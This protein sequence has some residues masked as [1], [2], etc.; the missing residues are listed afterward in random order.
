MMKSRITKIGTALAATVAVTAAL[1]GCTAGS[2]TNSN[3]T[4]TKGQTITVWSL[5]NQPDR[6][7]TTQHIID[8]FTKKTG[9]KVRIENDDEDVL[10]AQIEQEGTRSPADVFYTE[11]SNWLQQLDNRG[12][13]TRFYKRATMLRR[14]ERRL[15]VNGVPDLAT[16]TLA[17]GVISSNRSSTELPPPPAASLALPTALC[18]TSP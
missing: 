8:A 9:I 4:S 10:T 6:V 12:L 7:T 5:E 16:P 18:S 1:A 11:N 13:L 17:P 15:Q 3:S 2:T 14:I